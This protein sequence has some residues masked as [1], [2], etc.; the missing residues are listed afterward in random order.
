[1][2]GR[3]CEI[4][5]FCLSFNYIKSHGHYHVRGDT[6]KLCKSVTGCKWLLVELAGF[7]AIFHHSNLFLF[8]YGCIIH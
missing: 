7:E 5:Y 4:L 2:Q 3:M 6:Q 1:M 8:P